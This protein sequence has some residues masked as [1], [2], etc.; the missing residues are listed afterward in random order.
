[1]KPL[2][3]K[4]KRCNHG[5]LLVEHDADRNLSNLRFTADIL[6]ITGS[7]KHTTT[8]LDDITSST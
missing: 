8:M 4:W 3:G 1:M 6:L 2:T 5:V 7:L